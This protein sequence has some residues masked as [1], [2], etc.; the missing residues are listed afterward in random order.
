MLTELLNRIRPRDASPAGFAD[1]LAEAER[2][3]GAADIRLAAARAERARALLDAPEAVPSAE[4][5]MAEAAATRDRLASA[6]DVLRERRAAAEKAEAR[7]AA[8]RMRGTLDAEAQAVA[9]ALRAEYP[10]LARAIAALLAREAAIVERL[11]RFTTRESLDL[12]ASGALPA[13]ARPVRSPA[14]RVWQGT[15]PPASLAARVRLPAITGLGG[16]GDTHGGYWPAAP[17]GRG[18]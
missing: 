7:A 4:A 1:A 3:L 5:E 13:D 15:S 11:H 9:D 8:E 16:L 18:E 6:C 2:A 12:R 17:T 14:E 10:P